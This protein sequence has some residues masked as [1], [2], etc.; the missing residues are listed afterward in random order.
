MDSMRKIAITDGPLKG[1]TVEV[2][3]NESTFTTHAGNGHYEV[4]KDGAS[5]HRKQAATS[6]ET[7]A[8]KAPRK[9]VRKPAAKPQVLEPD[10]ARVEQPAPKAD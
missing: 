6:T 1:K 5:W 4:T 8:P 2:H 7:A 3:V 10:G 9:P